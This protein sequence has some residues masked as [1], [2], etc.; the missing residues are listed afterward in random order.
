MTIDAA[1][2]ELSTVLGDRLSRSKSDLD[3]HGQNESY[4]DTTPPDAVAYPTSTEEVQ[5]IV[6]ICARHGCPIVPWGVGTSLEGH[7]LAIRGGVSV[8]FSRMNRVLSINAEDMDCVVQP[9]ITRRALAEE[10]RATG[11]FFSVDPGADATLGGMAA[12]RASGTTAVRYGTMRDNVL[13][14]EVVLADGRVIRTG[15]RARKS[16][17]GY[18]LTALFLGSE[19]TL[20]LITELTLKLHGQPEAISSAV[21]AF[22]DIHAAVSAVIATIQMGIP[23][24]RI[25]FV[26]AATAQA[27][28]AYAGSSLPEM[29]HLMIE[30]HGSDTSVAEDATRFGEVAEEFGA[31]GFQWST[32]TE[33]RNKLWRMRH[34]AY[35]AIMASQPGK[36]AMATD[37]CVPISRLADAVVETQEDIAQSGLYG[38][39]L[40]HVGDGN[41]HATIVTDPTRPEE[42]KTAKALARRMNERALRMGGTVTGEHGVGM[43]KIDYMS[44]EHGEAWSVMGDLK[45]TLDPANILNP[46]KVVRLN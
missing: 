28:N 20:G 18:D 26:D 39:L 11:L 35:Y 34:D 30:F 36:R 19:G 21:C 22:P 4:F 46:G 33:E 8:D 38:P 14:L 9:G 5:E 40:G 43:G 41:F 27:F 32:K 2:A 44:E 23:M 15:T 42:L 1:I 6:K 12:T 37:I 7:A 3:L 29:P 25:E 10:L 24:A 45:R 31:E 13:G 16:S 17:A